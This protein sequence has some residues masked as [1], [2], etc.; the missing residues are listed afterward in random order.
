MAESCLAAVFVGAE[1]P[2][3]LQEFP[4]PD[5]GPEN[6]LVRMNMAAVCG[7][8]AH[9]WYNPNAPRPIIWV[10]VVNHSLE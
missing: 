3:E 9:N 2:L 7:T 6:I 5:V 8:D 1:R 10:P 4:V